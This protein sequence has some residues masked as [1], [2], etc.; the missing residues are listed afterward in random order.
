MITLV[1]HCKK[2]KKIKK[3]KLEEKIWA[4]EENIIFGLDAI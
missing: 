1:V 3:E 2:L 4:K